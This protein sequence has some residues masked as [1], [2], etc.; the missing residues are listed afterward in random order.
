MVVHPPEAIV[1]SH[2]RQQVR[3]NWTTRRARAVHV[4][5]KWDDYEALV[6]LAETKYAYLTRPLS[7]SVPG[8][9]G[10]ILMDEDVTLVSG[11]YHLAKARLEGKTLRLYGQANATAVL[12]I[13]T[14]N[15]PDAVTFNDE[16]ILIDAEPSSY[17]SIRAYL[18]GPSEEAQRY[19]PPKL[20]RWSF[21][22]SLPEMQANYND[23]DW[24]RA[25]KTSTY[26]AYYY[27]PQVSTNGH[28]LFSDEYGFHAGHIIW[29]GRFHGTGKETRFTIR[30]QGGSFFA[31]CLWLNGIHLGS[32]AG[33]A[34]HSDGNITASIKGVV[35]EGENILTVLHDSNGLEEAMDA[36]ILGA[37][38]DSP[39]TFNASQLL[40][41][42]AKFPLEGSKTPRGI[43]SYSFAGSPGTKIDSWR[44]Q[45]NY[46]GEQCPDRVRKCLNEGGL[47]AEVQGWHLPGFD[48]SDW[49][50]LL[51]DSPPTIPTAGVR[52][53]L[54]NITL[55]VPL[56][57]DLPMSIVFPD[58]DEDD[59]ETYRAQLYVN[60]WQFGKRLAGPG[61]Q[62]VFPVPPG[63][64]LPRGVNTIG[65]ALWSLKGQAT[66]TGGVQLRVMG[67]YRGE[68]TYDID[69][70]P[71]WSA[72]R[73]TTG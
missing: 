35:K 19:E 72:L 42:G 46:K 9:L 69:E 55:D 16:A 57:H 54:T 68:V 53:F 44:V 67:R 6:I 71:D 37:G 28:V 58:V 11:G 52:F 15:R 48:A 60:G 70:A 34:T 40:P 66:M 59:Q 3:L 61:P 4:Q 73:T 7:L 36:R 38:N 12:D 26:N 39:T 41:Q 62:T 45:G 2:D 25:D 1:V 21:A 23:D 29:R 51:E 22:D 49:P 43:L 10:S 31:G 64:L 13:L 14:S 65:L 33:N 56:G 18:P 47:H 20:D 50:V 63:V 8:S 30:L 24:V 17:G 27:L 5:L 32:A